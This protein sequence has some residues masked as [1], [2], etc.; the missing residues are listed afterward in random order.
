MAVCYVEAYVLQNIC[1]DAG[2]LWLASAWRGG[3]AKPLR[4]LAGALTGAGWALVAAMVGGILRSVLF[5]GITSFAM[6]WIALGQIT[7]VERIKAAGVLWIGA[8][9]LGGAVTMGMSMMTAGVATGMASMAMARRKHA[10]PPERVTLYIRR[11][12]VAHTME[13]MIDTGNRAIDPIS[14]LGVVFIPEC[15]FQPGVGHMLCIRTIAGTRL[16][17]CFLPDELTVNG[18]EVRGVVALAPVGFLETALVP[19]SFHGER[20]AS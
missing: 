16:M 12:I 19:S 8:T 14:G 3:R 11:G 13:A 5:Q 2:L 6:V 1:L 15:L 9:M 18:M 7:H 10:P 20:M 17:P 4:I